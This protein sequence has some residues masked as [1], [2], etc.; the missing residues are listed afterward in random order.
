MEKILTPD[1]PV[2]GGHY[3]QAVVHGGFVFISG[4]LPVRP[5]TG[6]KIHGSIQEQTTVVLEN[7][8]AIVHAAHSD[9]HHIVKVTIYIAGIDLWSGVN[10]VYA[11]FFGEHRPARTIVPVSGL[12]HGFLIE[13]DAIAAVSKE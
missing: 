11:D 1:A 10:E 2:P 8:R 13:V 5:G 9:L 4:Q 6:E 3:S 7:I 12:H